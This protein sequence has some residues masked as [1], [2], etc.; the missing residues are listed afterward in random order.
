MTIAIGLASWFQPASVYDRRLV[1]AM[2]DPQLI[3]RRVFVRNLDNGRRSSCFVIGT[4]P[5]VRGRV[6]DVSPAVRDQLRLDGI[7]PVR[8]TLGP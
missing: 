1:C 4:G 8:V 5:F 2:R 3:G 7:A 6:I